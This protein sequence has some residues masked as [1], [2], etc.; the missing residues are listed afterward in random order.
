MKIR[1]GYT[2]P[3][4]VTRVIDGDTI[5][6]SFT[7]KFIVRITDE[8]GTFNTPELKGRQRD[9]GVQAKNRLEELLKTGE[10]LLF[11]PTD[12]AKDVG[13][14][15]CIGGRV[16]GHIYIKGQDIAELMTEEGYNCA[17]EET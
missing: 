14:L 7:K 11:I 1:P 3:V 2:T 13:D 16:V 17:S 8:N 15:F 9:R 5:E 12:S 6:V 10:V 4:E